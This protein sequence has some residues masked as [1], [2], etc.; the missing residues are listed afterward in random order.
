MRLVRLL[1]RFNPCCFGLAVLAPLHRPET[2]ARA[3]FNPCCLP[4]CAPG[5]P[6]VFQSLLFWISRFGCTGDAIDCALLVG[7]NPCCFGLAVLARAGLDLFHS[8]YEVSILVV[9]D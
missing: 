4:G 8:I 9:L 3:G 2:P 7:F 6:L 5:V 1:I